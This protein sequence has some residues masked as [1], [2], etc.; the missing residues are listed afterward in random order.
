MF[1]D[2]FSRYLIDIMPVS[3]AILI[4]NQIAY[5]NNAA[6]ILLEVEDTSALI[7][8]PVSDFVHPLDI[9]RSNNRLNR[10]G[11]EWSNAPQ[12]FR[13]RSV[14]HNLRMLLVASLTIEFDGKSAILLVGM[15]MTAQNEISEQLRISEQNFRRLFDN[16]QDVYYRT[17]AKGVVLM[18]GPG[19]RTVL[20]YEPEEIVG[21]TAESYYPN[22]ADRDA[23]KQT[24][25]REGK[26]TD[27]GGQMV[28][29]DG[30]VIDI[31]ISSQAIYDDAGIFAGVEG[32]YRDVTQRKMLERELQRLATIDT[33]TCIQNRR[34][35]LENAEQLFKSSQRYD[36][37]ITLLMLDLDFFK[38]INDRYGHLGGDKV[39]VRFAQTVGQELRESD[40]FGRIGGEEFCIMLQQATR[41]DALIAAERIR[42]R[43]QEL[44]F[45]GPAGELFTLTVS[46]GVST[47]RADDERLGKLLERA[48]KALYQAKRSGRNCVIWED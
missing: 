28:R 21:K 16:M 12:Q 48:D 31:S 11:R 32:I 10:Q 39:L 45:D 41:E 43:V 3:L 36:T 6:A 22:V 9:T 44:V 20:G 37:S 14:K 47:N 1:T 30:R 13:L 4:D 5:A 23:L 17:D 46:I 15:D 26:V 29:K 34:A 25:A 7:G 42:E 24:I 27:F 35:F 38:A 40:L 18:V 33:L 2:A 8:R 19:V